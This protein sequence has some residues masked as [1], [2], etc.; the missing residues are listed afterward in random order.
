M[1][2]PNRGKLKADSPETDSQAERFFAAGADACIA[3]ASR[4]NRSARSRQEARH[5]GIPGAEGLPPMADL[6]A[7]IQRFNGCVTRLRAVP[8]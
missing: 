4:A 3:A 5:A 8:S 7:P 1:D 2:R 6:P